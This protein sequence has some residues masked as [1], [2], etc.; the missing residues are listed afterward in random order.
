MTQTALLHG[1]LLGQNMTLVGVLALDFACSGKSEPLFGTGIGFH[2]GHNA[3]FRPLRQGIALLQGSQKYAKKIGFVSLFLGSFGCQRNKHTL[4]FQFWKA[5]YFAYLFELLSKGEQKQFTTLLENNG[6]TS[7]MHIGSDLGT[8]LEKVLGVLEFELEIMIVGIRAKANL[9]NQILGGMGLD[10]FF[11]FLF[12]VLEFAVIS[13]SANG[14]GR[15][16]R[17]KDQVKAQPFGN[18]QGFGQGIDPLFHI[19]TDQANLFR[20]NVLID[21]INRLLRPSVKIR[22]TNRLIDKDLL[23][24]D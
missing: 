1:A 8:F 22:I 24:L 21:R 5:F 9:L 13:D 7:E 12:L 6:P 3:G 11:L 16:L 2:F 15:G 20:S 18:L 17:D 4:S 14:R 10:F 23:C 19:F